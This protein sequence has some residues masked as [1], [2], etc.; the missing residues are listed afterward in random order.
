MVR[1]VR[2]DLIFWRS[3]VI[4]STDTIDDC[5]ALSN[6]TTTTALRYIQHA[7]MIS[8]KV[9]RVRPAFSIADNCIKLHVGDKDY[10]ALQMFEQMLSASRSWFRPRTIRVV[11]SNKVGKLPQLGVR[12]LAWITQQ[13]S[14]ASQDEVN[15]LL[16]CKQHSNKVVPATLL[17]KM[18]SAI[19]KPV[20]EFPALGCMTSCGLA[21][22]SV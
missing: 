19:A 3:I 4:Y 2:I 1:V 5:A 14:A 16:L 21:G 12:L 20:F 18:G 15:R 17:A 11:A 7:C 6:R 9:L 8:C 22:A 10:P 13:T